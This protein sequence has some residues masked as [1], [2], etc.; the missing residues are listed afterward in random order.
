M[1]RLL[2]HHA[3]T[4]PAGSSYVPGGEL[5]QAA[6]DETAE[7]TQK[8]K[9]DQEVEVMGDWGYFVVLIVTVGVAILGTYGAT[10]DY[11]YRKGRLDGIKAEKKAS[12]RRKI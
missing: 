10:K 4:V 3:V 9:L 6:A 1:D 8:N 12:H 5:W 2:N 7:K 11:Y